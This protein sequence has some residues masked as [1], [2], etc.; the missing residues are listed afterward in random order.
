MQNQK[1]KIVQSIELNHAKL[2]STISPVFRTSYLGQ[3]GQAKNTTFCSHGT[4][5]SH[6]VIK[7]HLA[8]QFNVL[9]L[10]ARTCN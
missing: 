4:E 7:V 3:A 9:Q 8:I 2:K 5:N 1:K 10:K 6:C